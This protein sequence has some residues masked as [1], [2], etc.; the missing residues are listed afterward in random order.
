[1]PNK[2]LQQTQHFH[3]KNAGCLDNN[4][5]TLNWTLV[6]SELF[7]WWP[8]VKRIKKC[9][10]VRW[11]TLFQCCQDKLKITFKFWTWILKML[12]EEE[13]MEGDRN[14]HTSH[15]LLKLQTFCMSPS[16]EMQQQCLRPY[17]KEGEKNG[18]GFHTKKYWFCYMFPRTF[19]Q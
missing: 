8:H 2:Y 1:M 15:P 16:I 5:R 13:D 3:E 18:I 10:R 14:R 9:W 11:Y 6:Y 7:I 12:Q 17:L 4:Y 19:S